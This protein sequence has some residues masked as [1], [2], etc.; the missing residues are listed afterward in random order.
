MPYIYHNSISFINPSHPSQPRKTSLCTSIK[1]RSL[2]A[3]SWRPHPECSEWPGGPRTAA[4]ETSLREWARDTQLTVAGV[5]GTQPSSLQG[6]RSQGTVL[7]PPGLAG[8]WQGALRPWP[9]SAVGLPRWPPLPNNSALPE[10]ESPAL[11][12]IHLRPA[13]A[14]GISSTLRYHVSP[15]GKLRPQVAVL[16]SLPQCPQQLS[17]LPD[18]PRE[19]AP[20]GTGAT[21]G[22]RPLSDSQVSRAGPTPKALGVEDS[23]PQPRAPH[24]PPCP[25]WS[26]LSAAARAWDAQRPLPRA[27]KLDPLNTVCAKP[28]ACSCLRL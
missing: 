4:E 23:I 13:E 8:A 6:F 10:T 24:A 21:G 19:R 5:V 11:P 12:C 18:R 16:P 2:G 9:R 28:Y 1:A 15:A 22:L 27:A 3:P 25:S 17:S 26:W 14:P 20:R 7:L